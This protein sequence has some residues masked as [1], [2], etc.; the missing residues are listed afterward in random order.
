[1]ISTHGQGGE[2]T[3]GGFFFFRTGSLTFE[4]IF[5]LQDSSTSL[6]DEAPSS[7]AAPA[8]EAGEDDNKKDN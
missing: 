8:A 7:E 1:M 6:E 2:G 4:M 5:F 3:R